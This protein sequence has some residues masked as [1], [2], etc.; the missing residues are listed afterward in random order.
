[1]ERVAA[2]VDV[3]ALHRA[4]LARL[5]R[6][7][8]LR[9]VG[10]RKAAQ[11]D[12]AELVAAQQAHRRHD[13]AHAE[14]RADLL[15]LAAAARPGADHFLQRDDVRVDVPQHGGDAIGPRPSIHPAAAMDVVGD[16]AQRRGGVVAHSRYDSP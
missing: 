1:M 14:R 11:D 12:V 16:D 4:L 8:V 2:D 6:Q 9:V 7:I 13:P 3:R 15:D 10:D 5:P